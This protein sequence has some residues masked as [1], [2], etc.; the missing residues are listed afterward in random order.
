VAH[1]SDEITVLSNT[2]NAELCVR[3]LQ[4]GLGSLRRAG[5]LQYRPSA[6]FTSEVW[7]QVLREAGVRISMDC[8]GRWIDNAFIEWLWRT[9]KYEE[10]YLHAYRDG[11]EGHGSACRRTSSSTMRGDFTKR[12]TIERRMRCTSRLERR[13]V[14]QQHRQ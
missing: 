14:R 13:A 11:P 4:G 5:D 3:A 10:V 12:W 7:L 2:L 1:S 6:Q 8:K 9:V